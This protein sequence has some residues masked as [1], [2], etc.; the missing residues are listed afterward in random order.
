MP[1]S[2]RNSSNPPPIMPQT[3]VLGTS[4]ASPCNPSNP[5]P[6]IPQP[7]TLGTANDTI[8]PG[9]AP[10]MNLLTLPTTQPTQTQLLHLAQRQ[11]AIPPRD[12]PIL[13]LH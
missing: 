2:T 7:T 3:L 10:P 1:R 12:L 5:L 8:K 4:N 6:I 13:L 9:E 11:S